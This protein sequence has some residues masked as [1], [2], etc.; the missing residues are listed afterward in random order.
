MIEAKPKTDSPADMVTRRLEHYA[1]RGVFRGFSPVQGR[2]EKTIYRILWHRG[3]VF[4]LLLDPVRGTL[5]FPI[6][7]PEVPPDSKMYTALKAFIRARCSA[8]LPEH[9]SIDRARA[10]VRPYNRT[11]DVALTLKVKD[12]DFDYGAQKLVHLVHEIY[13]DFL[14]D[15]RYRDYMI[16][17]LGLDPDMD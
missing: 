8:E 3:R 11:G 5:K 17:Q 1:R 13:L 12:G 15:G 6:V 14:C 9:R 4:D 7:L 10:E 2:G 16:A